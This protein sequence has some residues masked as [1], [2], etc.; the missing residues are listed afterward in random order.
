MILQLIYVLASCQ[1]SSE[2]SGERYEEGTQD[3]MTPHHHTH[4][5]ASRP[6]FVKGLSTVLVRPYGIHYQCHDN[7]MI[8][9]Q[10]FMVHVVYDDNLLSY[11]LWGPIWIDMDRQTDI[12]GTDSQ[13][14]LDW[15]VW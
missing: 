4:E 8:E 11:S 1:S 5:A 10:K 12:D 3:I 6:L 9:I 2:P 13:W 7:A 15:L 14:L